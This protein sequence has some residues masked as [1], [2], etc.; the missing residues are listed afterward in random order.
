MIQAVPI[1]RS[2]LAVLH[3]VE[4]N[5]KVFEC[6]L[7]VSFSQRRDELGFKR[8][9]EKGGIV[10]LYVQY[11]KIILFGAV[12]RNKISHIAEGRMCTDNKMWSVVAPIG[13][14]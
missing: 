10:I 2:K 13:D 6:L 7:L 11:E 9:V 4:F 8:T 3:I 5:G 12:N 1:T 14:C